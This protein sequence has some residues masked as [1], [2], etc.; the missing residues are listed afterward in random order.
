M[1]FYVTSRAARVLR[2]LVVRWTSRLVRADAMVHAVT[3]QAE[4]IHRTEL[5]HSRISGPVRDV[6]RNTAVGLDGSMFEREWTLLVGV[7]LDAGGVSPDRQ[8]RLF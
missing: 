3:R 4:R 2:I 1:N 6:T 5:Q 8:P 7:T